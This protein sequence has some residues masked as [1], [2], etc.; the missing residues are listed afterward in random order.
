MS[1]KPAELILTAAEKRILPWFSY[2]AAAKAVA[3]EEI[4]SFENMVQAR[5]FCAVMREGL[6]SAT[7]DLAMW[8]AFQVWRAA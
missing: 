6:F 1:A 3:I 2:W 7:S 5:K 8:C 4:T